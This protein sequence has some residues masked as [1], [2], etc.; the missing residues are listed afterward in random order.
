MRL[1]VAET[2]IAKAFVSFIVGK[3]RSTKMLNK[4]TSL[5]CS[6]I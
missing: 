1:S 2:P 5:S 6:G 3:Q 4:A